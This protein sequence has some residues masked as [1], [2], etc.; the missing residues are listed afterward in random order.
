MKSC[1]L[2]QELQELVHLRK[3][4]SPALGPRKLDS[5][6]GAGQG[7]GRRLN[8]DLLES[9]RRKM[10]FPPEFFRFADGRGHAFDAHADGAVKI[11]PR[12]RPLLPGCQNLEQQLIVAD[13]YPAA[14]ST[15]RTDLFLQNF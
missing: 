14:L 15:K 1:R 9:L 12:A 2:L 13:S 7:C 5:L 3:T 6:A 11:L 8:L 4:N 10:S